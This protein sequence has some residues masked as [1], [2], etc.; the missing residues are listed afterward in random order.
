MLPQS[1]DTH[2]DPPPASRHLHVFLGVLLV[3]LHG[4]S[5]NGSDTSLKGAALYE[6]L[7]HV[8]YGSEGSMLHYDPVLAEL[9]KISSRGRG[10][11]AVLDVG[12]S[13]GGGVKALW[14]A[15]MVASGV[16][17]SKYAVDMARSRHGDDPKKCVDRCWQP[18]SATALP[19]ANNR[20]DAIISTDV[21]EHLEPFEV[22]IATSELTR[23]ARTWLL[24]K[25]SNRGESMSMHRL[26]APFANATFANAVKQRHDRDLPPQLHTTVHGAD[27]WIEKFKKA[28][29]EHH[30]SMSL[31]PW[32]CCG[33]VLRRGREGG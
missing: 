1:A 5:S 20:F 18:A 29:F 23:V 6:A 26:K 33:F 4:E 27:W 28:G 11:H 12:C 3:A 10:I 17:I 15:G 7:Y 2:V 8:G 9:K 16:D 14:N 30:H 22:D 32:A 19:F 13:H 25:I 24:L 21:L 31:P